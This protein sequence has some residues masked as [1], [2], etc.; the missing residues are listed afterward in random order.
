MNS[1]YNFYRIFQINPDNQDI[2]PLYNIVVNNQRFPQYYSIPRGPNFGGVD[3]YTL[4]G[5]D[6]GGL[7]NEQ[8][9]TL[10]LTTLY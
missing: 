10:T 1:R 3:L 7:W 5:R 4:I 2:Y 8:T 6:F 9:Q